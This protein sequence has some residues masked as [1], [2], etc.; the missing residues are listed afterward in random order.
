M[1]TG[2]PDEGLSQSQTVVH[3]IRAMLL[4]GE[5]G[6][7]SRLPVEQE[8]AARLAVS[9]G[10]LREG[11]RALVAMGV[12]E[13]RQG[14]GTYVTSLD[15]HLLLAP[16]GFVV[17]LHGAAG[18]RQLQ[19]VRRVL[20]TEAAAAAALQID[21]EVLARA[22][23]TLRRFEEQVASTAEPADGGEREPGDAL[24]EHQAAM[25][26]DIEFHRIIA[27]ASGNPVLEA[28]IEA[29][30]SRTVQGRLWRAIHDAGADERSHAEH[31]AI[32]A[33]IERRDPQTAAILMGAH[34]LA[35]EEFLARDD[36]GLSDLTSAGDQRGP[37]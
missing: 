8:L 22:D 2:M 36:S 21:E 27:R 11:V 1:T 7:R 13:T 26:I 37:T 18:A 9:R 28:L 16:V 6:P 20:E 31:R 19:Q 4:S 5:L 3:G 10:S 23:A 14:A 12:L 34:L 33:A 29:L 15:A 17:D 30:A 32:L 25:D 35:V 24:A